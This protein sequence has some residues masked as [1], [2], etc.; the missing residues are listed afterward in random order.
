MNDPSVEPKRFRI[1]VLVRFLNRR[2]LHLVHSSEL[3]RYA[4]DE[5]FWDSNQ[6]TSYLTHNAL[7]DTQTRNTP[8]RASGP[9]CGAGHLCFFLLYALCFFFSV[10][11]FFIKQFRV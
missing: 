10:F 2:L 7:G 3:P 5:W 6:G 1:F 11:V 8:P 9:M 4:E